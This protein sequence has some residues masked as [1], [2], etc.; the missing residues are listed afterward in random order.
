MN[1]V[2]VGPIAK[3]LFDLVDNLFTSDEER[4]AAKAKIIEM[5]QAGQLAQIEVN[6]TEAEHASVFV[7]GWRPFVGWTCGLAFAW[8]FLCAP[9]SAFLLVALGYPPETLDAL[10]EPDLS[11]MMPVLMGMLGLGAMRSWEKKQ[12][13]ARETLNRYADKGAE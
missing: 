8:A 13:V 11:G 6:K 12:G 2:A 4:A 9:V 10:P 5:E 3:G 7:A 1:L